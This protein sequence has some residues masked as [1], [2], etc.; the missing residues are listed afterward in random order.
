MFTECHKF[1]EGRW[2]K[3][4]EIVKGKKRLREEEW[5]Q[6]RTKRGRW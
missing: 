2:L 5:R 1:K 6:V 4:D 3:V